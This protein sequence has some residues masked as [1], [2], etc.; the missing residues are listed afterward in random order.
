[1]FSIGLRSGNFG[2][3]W[4]NDIPDASHGFSCLDWCVYYG[5][6]LARKYSHELILPRIDL[7]RK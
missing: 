4:I 3:S 6:N 5:L 7:Y 2:G 1:M